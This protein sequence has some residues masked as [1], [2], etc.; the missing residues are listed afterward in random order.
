MDTS[1]DSWSFSNDVVLYAMLGA[2]PNEVGVVN[3]RSSVSSKSYWSVELEMTPR[4]GTEILDGLSGVERK[5]AA[6]TSR[7]PRRSS[8]RELEHRKSAPSKGRATISAAQYECSQ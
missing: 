2:R 8:K 6:S 1:M 7:L 4:Q 5:V 3:S